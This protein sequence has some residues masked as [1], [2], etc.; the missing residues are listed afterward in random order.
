SPAMQARAVPAAANS[1]STA[2]ATSIAFIFIL[3]GFVFGAV[4]SQQDLPG[5]AIEPDVGHEVVVH[6]LPGLV[7]IARIEFGQARLPILSRRQERDQERLLVLIELDG[8][9]PGQAL[10]DPRERDPVEETRETDGGAGATATVEHDQRLSFG[11]ARRGGE[12]VQEHDA[13]AV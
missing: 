13:A 6:A 9:D 5:V 12:A 2:P 1:P 4:V 8:I 10:G 3:P 11:I 7:A